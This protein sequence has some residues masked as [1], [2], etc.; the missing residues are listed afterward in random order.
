[1]FFH[2]A[3]QKA[4]F[5]K[6]EKT[7][8][9]KNETPSWTKMPVQVRRGFVHVICFFFLRPPTLFFFLFLFFVH[10]H[11]H[12]FY[13]KKMYTFFAH[14][15]FF[16]F[17]KKLCCFFVLFNGDIMKIYTNFT[18]PSSHFSFQRSK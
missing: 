16:F 8:G 9:E 5:L 18:L 6:W 7:G 2:R 4:F 15:P 11:I 13:A 14:A 1:M 3:H 10:L 17:A 12:N